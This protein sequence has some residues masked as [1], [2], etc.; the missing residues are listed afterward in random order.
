MAAASAPGSRGAARATAP[1]RPR[2]GCDSARPGGGLAAGVI[3]YMPPHHCRTQ[4][5]PPSWLGPAKCPVRTARVPQS[6]QRQP[7]P[8]LSRGWRPSPA[9]RGAA[10]AGGTPRRGGQWCTFLC[11]RAGQGEG[12]LQKMPI[13]RATPAPRPRHARATVL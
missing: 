5:P 8:H 2:R 6:T 3:H 9:W 1:P 12:G 13:A 10:A 11:P 7:R 4:V